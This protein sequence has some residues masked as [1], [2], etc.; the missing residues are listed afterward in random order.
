MKISPKLAIGI[1]ATLTVLLMI[2]GGSIVLPLG[3]S[4][5]AVDIIKSWCLFVGLVVGAWGTAA[6]LWSA[7]IGGPLA[8]PPTVGEARDIL[9][10]AGLALKAEPL[11][12]PAPSV[13]KPQ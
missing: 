7:P 1:A 2:G 12:P 8:A 4:H 9:T 11:K 13:R 6:G 10:Q 3:L 5:E